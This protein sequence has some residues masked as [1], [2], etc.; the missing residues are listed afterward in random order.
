MIQ[1]IKKG[2]S[3]DEINALSQS[4]IYAILGSGGAKITKQ[5][6]NSGWHPVWGWLEPEEIDQ[7]QLTGGVERPTLAEKQSGYILTEE[8]F[9]KRRTKEG[10]GTN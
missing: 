9:N 2:Y 3:P 4:A 10:H 8:E 6:R 5:A 1:L 7:L